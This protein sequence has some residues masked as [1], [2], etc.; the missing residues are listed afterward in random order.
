MTAP[1]KKESYSPSRR[2]ALF[3]GGD[4]EHRLRG[5]QQ[6]RAVDGWQPISGANVCVDVVLKVFVR[7]AKDVPL[8]RARQ[9]CSSE[10]KRILVTDVP[11][12]VRK[13]ECKPDEVFGEWAGRNVTTQQARVIETGGERMGEMAMVGFSSHKK[14]YFEE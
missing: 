13:G 7:P 11:A 4:L 3:G 5:Q 6:R 10:R 9:N 12:L 8:A 2:V 14:S 1:N